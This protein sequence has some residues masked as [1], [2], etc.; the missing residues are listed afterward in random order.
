MRSNTIPIEWPPRSGRTI[1]I[2]EVDQGLF[3]EIGEARRKLNPAQEPFLDRLLAV[4]EDA[5]GRSG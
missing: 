4:L 5:D 3:F 2:P 1:E